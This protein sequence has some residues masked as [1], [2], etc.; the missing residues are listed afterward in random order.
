MASRMLARCVSVV[1]TALSL[2]AARPAPAADAY[3]C[4]PDNVVYVEI[5]NLEA[6]KRSDPCIATYYELKIEPHSVADPAG[7]ETLSGRPPDAIRVLRQLRPRLAADEPVASVQSSAPLRHAK[8]LPAITAAAGTDYR[9]VRVINAASPE[10][11]WFRHR[12]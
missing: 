5:E 9:N 3:L 4:G 10:N 2:P 11:A 8:T 6:M 7:A 12:K 1:A